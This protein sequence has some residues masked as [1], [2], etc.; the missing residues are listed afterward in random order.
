MSNIIDDENSNY[1]NIYIG[2]CDGRK[3]LATTSGIPEK[4][5]CRIIL[6]ALKR[7]FL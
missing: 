6:K 1:V 4:Y 2:R 7:F 5:D 3:S